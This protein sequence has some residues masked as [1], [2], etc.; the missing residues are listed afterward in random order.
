MEL[1][2][3]VALVTGG[4]SGIGLALCERFAAEGARGV[5]VVDLEGS[6]AESVAAGL[7][8]VGLGLRADVAVETDMV[9]AVEAVEARFGPIDLL[10]CN[11]G[12]GT[13]QG[14]AAPTEAWQ[15]LWDVNVMAHVFALRAVLPGMVAR[16]GGYVLTT[17]SAAGLLTNIG[18][19]AYTATKHAAVGLAEWVAITYGDDGIKVS[20]LCPQGVRTPLL[21]FAAQGEAGQTVLT[22]KLLGP[23]EVAHAVIT[24]LRE[25]RF[26]ILPHPE[27]HAYQQRKAA[28]RDRWLAGMRRLQRRV[29]G[30]S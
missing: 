9:A 21:D 27:V 13:N 15:H 7:G 6:A 18:D 22:E 28:D 25:A 2:G 4:A 3:A 16:G 12:V 8:D 1:S 23:E 11:A 26:L 5:A 30:G 29:R 19:A 24:G 10:V 14:L 20:C 17:A